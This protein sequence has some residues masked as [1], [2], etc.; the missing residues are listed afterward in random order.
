MLTTSLLLPATTT[1][2]CCAVSNAE[3]AEAVPRRRTDR[4]RLISAAA[5]VLPASIRSNVRKSTSV[6]CI[7]PN[8]RTV[9]LYVPIKSSTFRFLNAGTYTK[10]S[11]RLNSASFSAALLSTSYRLSFAHNMLSVPASVLSSCIYGSMLQ[12][13]AAGSSAEMLPAQRWCNPRTIWYA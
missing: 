13:A 12:G 1:L 6:R 7:N 10:A 3:L 9:V 8:K 5:A 11:I 4:M 2:I